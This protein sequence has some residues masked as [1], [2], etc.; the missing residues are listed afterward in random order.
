MSYN[1]LRFRVKMFQLQSAC[2]LNGESG[3]TE[4]PR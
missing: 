2:I 4:E 1:R 3:A